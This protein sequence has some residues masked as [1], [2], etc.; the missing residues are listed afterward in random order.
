MSTYIRC[1]QIL[2]RLLSTVVLASI[3]IWSIPGSAGATNFRP[4]YAD[5]SD[6]YYR[7]I[8]LESYTIVASDWGRNRIDATDMQTYVDD[9]C[10]IS[11]PSGSTDVCVYDDDYTGVAWDGVYGKVNCTILVLTAPHKCDSFRM[12][13]DTGNLSN[14]SNNWLRR[15]GCHEWGHTTGLDHFQRGGRRLFV[16]VALHQLP[17]PKHLFLGTRDCPHQ[18]QI[19]VN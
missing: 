9:L 1:R 13:F 8:D 11:V 19:L 16:H 2:R 17:L 7:Y 18:W 15:A 5:N 3:V 12:R 4:L 6:H 10:T 14:Y